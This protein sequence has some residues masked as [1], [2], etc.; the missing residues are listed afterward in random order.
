MRREKGVMPFPLNGVPDLC[1]ESPW[2]FRRWR[3][4][5]AFAMQRLF[6]TSHACWA[7]TAI[8]MLFFFFCL[9][10]HSYDCTAP[11]SAIDPR[12]PTW[13]CHFENRDLALAP[14]DTHLLTHLQV[15]HELLQNTPAKSSAV[16]YFPSRSF[17]DPEP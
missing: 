10:S 2:I 12:D 4:H 11:C 5:L 17:C 8:V 3:V 13:T 7:R 14:L 6:T 1:E 9:G 16:V 15:A